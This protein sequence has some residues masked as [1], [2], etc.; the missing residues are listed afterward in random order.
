MSAFAFCAG[1]DCGE[2]LGFVSRIIAQREVLDPM[3]RFL[4]V[5]FPQWWPLHDKRLIP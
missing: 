3:S 4:T 5:S 2:E 1:Q